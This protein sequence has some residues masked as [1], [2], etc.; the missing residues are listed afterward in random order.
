M[1]FFSLQGLSF[2]LPILLGLGIIFAWLPKWRLWSLFF[3]SVAVAISY[4]LGLVKLSGIW[5]LLGGAAL[6][7]TYY[8]YAFHPLAKVVLGIAITALTMLMYMHNMPGFHNGLVFNNL[9]FAA[10]SAPYQFYLNLDKISMGLFFL[11]FG[12]PLCRT[13]KDW[14]QSFLAA[15]VPLGLAGGVLLILS[16]SFH[17]VR[18]DPKIPPISFSWCVLNLLFVVVIEEAFFRGFLQH[19]L[20][21]AFKKVSRGLP[22]AI[23]ISAILFG[24]THFPGGLKAI[25]A[26]LSG[27]IPYQG[28]LVYAGLAVVAGCIYGYAYAH[29]PRLESAILTHFGLN[30]VHFFFFSYP[31]LTS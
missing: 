15:L 23:L 5:A 11:L 14:Q 8:V 9:T 19:Q 12:V 20:A 10:D 1:M 22:L 26:I 21:L 3:L 31:A 13:S 18:F 24:V 16:L 25:V 17:Y 2:F 4:Y 27:K 7:Y 29:Y 6:I 30:L 28:G